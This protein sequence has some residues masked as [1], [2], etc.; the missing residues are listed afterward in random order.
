VQAAPFRS[1]GEYLIDTSGLFVYR[2]DII[3]EK[4]ARYLPAFSLHKKIFPAHKLASAF[5]PLAV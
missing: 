3:V 4:A 2:N 5:P 1:A